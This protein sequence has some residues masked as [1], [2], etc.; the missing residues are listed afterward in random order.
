[1][2]RRVLH[3][4]DWFFAALLF[5]LTLVADAG[6]VRT[7]DG[8]THSGLVRLVPPG[9]VEVIPIKGTSVRVAF[10]NVLS[11]TFEL[12][13]NHPLLTAKFPNAG[14]GIGLVGA[15]YERPNFSGRAI[16]RVD[17]VID[18]NWGAREP[19]FDLP[20]DYF[21]V[22]WSGQLEAPVGGLYTFWL[23]TDD[24]GRMQLGPLGNILKLE[25]WQK[26][27]A[28]ET[29]G[30]VRLEA[31]Q[32]YDLRLE[33]FDNVGNA[34]VRL[35]WSGPGFAKSIVPRSQLYPASPP[36]L[37]EAKLIAANGLLATYFKSRFF[38]GD[39]VVRV[40][41]M[42]NFAWTNSPAGDVAAED[43]SV[44][45]TGQIEAKHSE[46]YTF[47]V[48][49]DEGVRLW[50]NGKSLINELFAVPRGQLIGSLALEAGKRYEL[51]LETMN[52]QGGCTARL[53]WSSPSTAKVVIPT[54]QLFPG[55]TP[56]PFH[57]V[58]A[59]G[60]DEGEVQPAGVLTWAGSLLPAPI[61]TADDTAIR[62]GST[63]SPPSISLVNVARLY[64]QP[65]TSRATEKI[66]A[67]RKGVLL[68]NGDFVDG[69]FKGIEGG[70]VT[71]S[72][73]L[74]GLQ[75]YPL[76]EVLAVVLRDVPRTPPVGTL[77]RVGLS[78]GALLHAK[79]IAVSNGAVVVEDPSVGTVML[80]VDD[81][82]ELKRVNRPAK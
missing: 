49:S 43:Y 66:P 8:Q 51:R 13:E 47:H 17:E 63:H 82:R 3:R 70:R 45:W 41:P 35:L 29:N 21:T 52:R 19:V 62:F 25:K 74:F 2:N 76:P 56:P 68:A 71:V 32:R 10:T 39:A 38:F 80:P 64:L 69:E 6:T 27:E 55:V 14:R 4:I 48:E 42:V 28:G 59:P 7:L 72:S 61:Q 58:I 33:Y 75:A 34:R 24:G 79:T 11:A 5:F 67:G 73:V 20:R 31:G 65:L 40:D 23:A 22:R 9:V 46:T 1:M 53:F 44:R 16:Y 50:V 77:L 15:Y 37:P 78:S 81:L 26:Q 18:F 36:D 60:D 12:P 30:V 54:S 57:R